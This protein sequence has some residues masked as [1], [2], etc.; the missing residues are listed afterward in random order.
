MLQPVCGG[1]GRAKRLLLQFQ[2]G[3]DDWGGARVMG[4]KRGGP[5]GGRRNCLF[6]RQYSRGR[7]EPVTDDCW[8]AEMLLPEKKRG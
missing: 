6:E 2:V 7:E 1:G 4:L 5:S 8:L 3:S